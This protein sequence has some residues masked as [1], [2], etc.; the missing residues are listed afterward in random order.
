MLVCLYVVYCQVRQMHFFWVTVYRLEFCSGIV[1]LCL[2]APV[3]SCHII[4]V[5]RCMILLKATRISWLLTFCWRRNQF[6]ARRA[7]QSWYF[8][9]YHNGTTIQYVWASH[10]NFTSCACEH[11]FKLIPASFFLHRSLH[12]LSEQPLCYF[13]RYLQ[14]RASFVEVTSVHLWPKIAGFNAR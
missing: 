9:C 8:I 5:C 2:L 11:K 13:L 6:T 14:R 7:M 3:A 12:F 10:S 4:T 1:S